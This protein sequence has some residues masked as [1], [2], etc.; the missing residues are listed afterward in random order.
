MHGFDEINIRT[1]TDDEQAGRRKK[2]TA[3]NIKRG[4]EWLLDGAQR[5][6]KLFFHYSG[7]G[8]QVE[9]VHGDEEDGF[10]E[11]LCPVSVQA[12]LLLNGHDAL[13]LFS[14]RVSI[15]VL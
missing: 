4:F 2:P 7:H 12:L 10:D 1:L 5:G 3:R 15:F 11:A 9:D 14:K 8:T 6:D 13:H